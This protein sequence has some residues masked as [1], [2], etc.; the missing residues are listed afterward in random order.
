[1]MIWLLFAWLLPLSMTE[2]T[3]QAVAGCEGMKSDLFLYI[4]GQPPTPLGSQ[5]YVLKK[6][7][8]RSVAGF[9][10]PGGSGGPR[11]QVQVADKPKPVAVAESRPLFHLA[12][13]TPVERIVAVRL[14]ACGN[15]DCFNLYDD[16]AASMSLVR[17]QWRELGP[18]CYEF[19]PDKSLSPGEYALVILGSDL[20]PQQ[21]ARFVSGPTVPPLEMPK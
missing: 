19:H 8:G 15:S 4:G 21:V 5:K 10:I 14:N 18:G 12:C 3:E 17:L 11:Y 20:K 6:I 7:R 16:G 13:K 9:P 2:P 1:M